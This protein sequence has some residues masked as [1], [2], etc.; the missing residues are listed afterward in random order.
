MARDPSFKPHRG[1]ITRHHLQS[2]PMSSLIQEFEYDIF[3]SYRQ[4]D[5]KYDSWVT[6]F[7]N[8]LNK[9]LEATLKEKV[10]VYFDSNPHDG[11]L[12]THSVERSLESKLKCLI[13]IPILSKT[14]CDSTSFAWNYEFLPFIEQAGR[15]Q[16]GLNVKLKSGNVASRVLPVRI[17]DLDAEDTQLAESFLGVVRAVDFIYHS[18]GVNRSLRPWDDDVIKNT[19]Q[20]FYRDQINKVANAVDEILHGLKQ[21]DEVSA[22]E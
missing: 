12:E 18:P 4:G 15:D 7:V 19:K 22:R 11:L 14:Y 2:V 16:F 20:P 9:E 1:A 8:N 10:T 21:V 17:H 5:N 6:E 3:I 13:F